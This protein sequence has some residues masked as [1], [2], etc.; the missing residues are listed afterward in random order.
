MKREL[1]NISQ[2]FS[3]SNAAGNFHGK[4]QH[5]GNFMKTASNTVSRASSSEESTPSCLETIVFKEVIEDWQHYLQADQE[6]GV[7]LDSLEQA[8][9]VETVVHTDSRRLTAVSSSRSRVGSWVRLPRTSWSH[10]DSCSY[11]LQKIDNSIFKQIKS[12][13]LV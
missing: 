4:F 1:E 3:S 11:R 9:L 12:W 5:Q 6:L 7:G 13:E 2:V 10:W 8:D